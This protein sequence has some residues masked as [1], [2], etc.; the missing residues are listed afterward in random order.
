MTMIV[1][2]VA[3]IALMVWFTIPGVAIASE[4][5]HLGVRK[6]DQIKVSS[7]R[8]PHK[9]SASRAPSSRMSDQGLGDKPWVGHDTDLAGNSYLYYRVGEDSPFGPGR[10]LRGRD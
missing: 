8:R 9:R 7:A 10:G 6:S 5:S 1:R 4:Q 3:G 2:I